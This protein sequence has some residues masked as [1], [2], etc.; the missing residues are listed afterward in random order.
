M[1]REE[2]IKFLKL[3]R[4]AVSNFEEYGH[5]KASMVIECDKAEAIDMAIEALQAD[6]EA[7]KDCRTCVYGR[8]NDHIDKWVCYHS[9][10]CN[11]FDLWESAE[12]N[13]E[14]DTEVRLWVT[15]RKKEKVILWDAF[16]EVEYYP[17][18]KIQIDDIDKAK[19][20]SQ[21][22]DDLAVDMV[23]AMGKRIV[24]VVRC[25]DCIHWKADNEVFELGFCCV[26]PQKW[27]AETFYCADGERREE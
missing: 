11:D 19:T 9:C 18:A 12:P 1:T 26:F 6:A 4:K 22:L 8:Y 13:Y 2:A 17:I 23:K 15:N 16:D 27:V 7:V 21:L 20:S 10:K 5:D 25:K 24:E 3:M 14:T